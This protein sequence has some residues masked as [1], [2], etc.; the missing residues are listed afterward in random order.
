[1]K[2]TEENRDKIWITKNKTF[3][4]GK[5]AYIYGGLCKNC[6]EPF[7][8][9]KGSV[10][11]FCSHKCS[12][13]GKYNSMYNRKHTKKSK[14]KMSNERKGKYTGK[15]SSCYKGGVRKLN[16]PLY[17]TYETQLSAF[18]EVRPYMV[19]IDGVV[20]KTLQV[21]CNES[22][23]KRWFTP[24][25]SQVGNRIQSFSGEMRGQNNFYCSGECKLRCS[26]FA[27][28]KFFKGQNDIIRTYSMSELKAWAREVLRR[29]NFICACCGGPAT[30][31]HH[32]FSKIEYPEYALDPFYGIALCE[33]CH[34]PIFHKGD[35]APIHFV[36]KCR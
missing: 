20:Y 2:L 13:F 17:D 34:M 5:N 36:D 18:E 4:D 30:I 31:G 7:I 24:T 8:A 12:T 25:I 32:M 29:A 35:N 22:D 14:Q 19:L 27:Q 11:D 15:N 21:K 16:I 26:T 6:K 23:C 10:G 28:K 3:G 33:L 1:M 9:I